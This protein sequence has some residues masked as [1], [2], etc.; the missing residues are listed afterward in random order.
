MTNGLKKEGGIAVFNVVMI[1][2]TGIGCEIGGHSGD[3]TPVAKML[4]GCCD[5]LFI[6]PNVVNASDINEMTRNMAYIEGSILD[7]FL[8]GTVKLEK[9]FSNKILLVT[10]KPI[11]TETV[12]AVNAARMTIGCEIE[13]VEL[14]EE[15]KM[16]ANITEEGAGGEVIGVESLCD[17][18]SN[19]QFDALAIATAID[20]PKEVALNYLRNGGINPWGGVEAI[21]S[22]MIAN[23]INKP[24]AHAPIESEDV[25]LKTLNEVVDCRVAAEMI[26]QCYIHCVFKG[27]HKAPRINFDTGL[28]FKDVH[29]LVSPINCVGRPHRACMRHG[30]PVIAVKENKTCL[31]DK[32]PKEFIVVE[33][34]LEAVGVIVAM[35]EGIDTKTVRRPVNFT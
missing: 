6:H 29:C 5:T 20:C 28:S 11:R 31:N 13:I 26:S 19:Y 2:P 12:N 27:L 10:N 18:V 17:Q 8:E 24:V 25:E 7:R 16:I 32:M 35:K 33:N 3:S 14:E 21:A 22:K 9:P 15:L 30:I 34:Y 1:I 23:K 4:A